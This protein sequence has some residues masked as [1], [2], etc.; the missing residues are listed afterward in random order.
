MPGWLRWRTP[1][2]NM[3]ANSTLVT[4]GSFRSLTIYLPLNLPMWVLRSDVSKLATMMACGRL[5]S[6]RK[7]GQ[8]LRDD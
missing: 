7:F 1:R 6:D 3:I 2:P 5:S 8:R 4:H